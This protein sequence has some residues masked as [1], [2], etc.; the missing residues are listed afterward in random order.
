MQE[1][2]ASKLQTS[3]MTITRHETGTH[4]IPGVVEVVLHQL[5]STPILPLVG[6]VAAG[7]P[8]EPI[9]QA[10]TVDVPPSM[11]G[12]GESFGLRRAFPGR[13]RRN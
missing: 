12:R 9:L 11:L 3:R 10:E 6:F 4:R 2:L 13:S 7:R 8:I 1:A 5:S